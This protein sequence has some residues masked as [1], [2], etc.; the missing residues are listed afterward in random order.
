MSE[1]LKE[2]IMGTLGP[3][4]S[5]VVTISTGANLTELVRRAEIIDSI[6]KKIMK[7]DVHYG[8]IPGMPVD[9]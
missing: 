7:R 5:S 4:K 9:V 2:E 8:V 3:D 6:F 1:T